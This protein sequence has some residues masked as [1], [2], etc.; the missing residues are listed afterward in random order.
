[1]ARRLG[2]STANLERNGGTRIAGRQEREQQRGGLGYRGTRFSYRRGRR[3]GHRSIHPPN[4]ATPPG[5]PG[6]R[7]PLKAP[8]A[9]LHAGF[10]ESASY[11][12]AL[13]FS[14]GSRNKFLPVGWWCKGDAPSEHGVARRCTNRPVPGMRATG[15]CPYP[16][17]R[18]PLCYRPRPACSVGTRFPRTDPAPVF[19]RIINP[20]G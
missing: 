3:R 5:P 18:P 15:D 2:A 10:R 1:M 20:E 9:P 17:P 11:N 12:F 7:S 13:N 14:G 19:R 8:S 16:H 6:P 4:Q